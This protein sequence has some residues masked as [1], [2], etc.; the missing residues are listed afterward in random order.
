MEECCWSVCEKEDWYVTIWQ[1]RT[2]IRG[3]WRKEG[4]SIL[5]SA[6]PLVKLINTGTQ[7]VACLVWAKIVMFQWNWGSLGLFWVTFYC[8]FDLNC[9][10]SAVK[11][12]KI[13][14]GADF[15]IFSYLYQS[16]S[17]LGQ[18][19]SLSWKRWR[20]GRFRIFFYS[21]TGWEVRCGGSRGV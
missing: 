21:P 13:M 20:R 14:H 16:K 5:N 4:L 18:E 12:V 8:S 15:A 2:E 6:M 10:N 1:E 11:S 19:L 17:Q 9:E 3:L 7:E